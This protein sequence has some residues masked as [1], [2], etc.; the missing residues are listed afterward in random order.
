MKRRVL[1]RR[2]GSF[3]REIERDSEGEGELFLLLLLSYSSTLT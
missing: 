2:G 3:K 1:E